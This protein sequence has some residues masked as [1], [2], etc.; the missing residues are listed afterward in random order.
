MKFLS[1][2]DIRRFF[3]EVAVLLFL[4]LL[5]GL[6]LSQVIGRDFEEQLLNHDY[7]VAGRLLRQGAEPA[8]V[9]AALAAAKTAEE[10]EAGRDF[11]QAQGFSAGISGLLPEARALQLK[12]RLLLLVPIALFGLLSLWAFFR[13]FKGQ[14]ETIEKADASIRAFMGGDSAARLDSEAEGC[15][16]HLFASVNELATSLQ[17][18]LETEKRAKESFKETMADISHQL[19]TPLAALKLN[20]EIIRAE[21]ASENTVRE[22]SD[23]SEAALERMERLI[24][25]L[26]KIARLD[27]GA[28]TLQAKKQKIRVLLEKIVSVFETRAERE[29]KTITLSGP[30]DAVLYCDGDWL[31][32]AIGNLVKNALDHTGPGGRIRIGWQETPAISRITVQDQGRGIHPEDIH[33]I[34]KRF[35][36]S[37]FS[38]ETQGIGLGLPLAK[39]IVEAHNGTITV[40]SVLGEGTTFTLD[41]LKLT[42]L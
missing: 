33:H 24:D 26:L 37:R 19:K 28:I 10:V 35:Y 34:F 25:N 14:Q 23:K 18:H 38:Q 12:Y 7:G 17:A 20:N 15:L 13:Y 1:N 32:E 11:L 40:D 42:E 22:F 29:Q 16:S 8:A 21:S 9:S 3:S 31:A 2:R 4:L 41:F 36:R 27:A 30:E 5:F 6:L 39:A